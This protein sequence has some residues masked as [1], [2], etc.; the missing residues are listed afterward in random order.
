MMDEFEIVTTTERLIYV[1]HDWAKG[2]Q[3]IGLGGG[4][5]T[6]ALVAGAVS[7]HK[8][9]ARA[10]GTALM[11]QIPFQWPLR[12]S[13]QPGGG[14]LGR[15]KTHVYVPISSKTQFLRFDL[16][17][18]NVDAPGFVELFAAAVNR[19]RLNAPSVERAS[20]EVKALLARQA[21]NPTPNEHGNYEL[22]W[23]ATVRL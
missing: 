2:N 1:K 13:S 6:I 11:G 20:D 3:Y 16:Q 8:A 18:P 12:I 21:E 14:L 10:A 5:A 4:G 23:S 22:T 9:K 7:K 17:I 15:S 19:Y